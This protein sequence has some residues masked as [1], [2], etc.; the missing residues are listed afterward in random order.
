[1]Q[2]GSRYRLGRL[3]LC[4]ASCLVPAVAAGQD[5]AARNPQAYATEVA[6][7]LDSGW[8]ESFRSLEPAGAYYRRARQISP[9]DPRAIYAYVLVQI[10]HRRYTDA[11]KLLDELQGLAPDDPAAWQA[12]VWL[13]VLTRQYS[14]ALVDLERFADIIPPEPR[15]GSLEQPW[16]DAAGY[17]GKMCAFLSG[18]LRDTVD[19]ERLNQVRQRI[20]AVMVGARQARF[21]EGYAAVDRR[22]TELWLLG[23]QTQE[24]AQQIEAQQKAEDAARLAAEQ[25]AI[26]TARTALEKQAADARAR[27]DAELKRLESQQSELART[28]AQLE[29]ELAVYASR[30]GDLDVQILRLRDLADATEDPA[31]RLRY[32]LDADRLTR[33]RLDEQRRAAVVESLVVRQ[34]AALASVLAQQGA[35]AAQFQAELDRLNREAVA[36][37]RNQKRI[38]NEQREAAQPPTGNTAQVRAMQAQ[39]VSLRTYLPF[40]LEEEKQRLLNSFKL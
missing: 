28:L 12:R 37:G 32:Q 31:R 33:L 6:L 3:W 14:A 9:D 19:Q 16:L 25:A 34:R 11:L 36:L 13:R 24:Q 38:R 21:D 17:L 15:V 27:R 8:G 1:M 40:P 23:E 10:K 29:A 30:I 5:S 26:D 18:P 39:A 20:Q 4:V 7:L 2:R 22:F 35:V